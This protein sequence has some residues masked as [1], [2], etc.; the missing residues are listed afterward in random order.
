MATINT[1]LID[2]DKKFCEQFQQEHDGDEFQIDF[3]LS[4]EEAKVIL[5]EDFHKYHFVILDGL[6][7]TQKFED[8]TKSRGR[9]EAQFAMDA[10]QYIKEKVIYFG[11]AMP[12]CVLTGW[13]EDIAYVKNQTEIFYKGKGASERTRLIS[14]IRNEYTRLEETTFRLKHPEI[15]LVFDRGWLTQEH[16]YDLISLF[17]QLASPSNNQLKQKAGRV[18]VIMEAVYNKL[19]TVDR[20]LLPTNIAAG[21]DVALSSAIWTVAGKPTKDYKPYNPI[22]PKHLYEI[23]SALQKSV[24]T[25]T[26]HLYEHS[27]SRYTLASY[28]NS[29][30]D[31]LLWFSD[32]IQ[33][34]SQ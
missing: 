2:D 11:R 1:L 22:M 13:P 12:F 26:M 19:A 14:Y 29:L 33:K 34:R 28:A 3:A 23:V 17:N 25:S 4:L 32:F 15:A 30:A 5:E 16:K 20:T 31:L 10:I 9:G 27:I 8:H 7:A 21:D 18:R 24:S 6:G